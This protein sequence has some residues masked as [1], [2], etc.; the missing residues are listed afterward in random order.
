MHQRNFV[1]LCCGV[2]LILVKFLF[3]F[4]SVRQFSFML[5]LFGVVDV[6][7]DNQEDMPG[8]AT[9]KKVCEII[10]SLSTFVGMWSFKCLLP[11]MTQSIRAEDMD[12]ERLASMERH[13]NG[14]QMLYLSSWPKDSGNVNVCDCI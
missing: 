11:L 6:Y 13:V 12:P 1:L 7:I 9:W 10:I 5:P 8:F 2:L 14:C 3:F 4:H